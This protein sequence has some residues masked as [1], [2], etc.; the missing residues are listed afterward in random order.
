MHFNF[1]VVAVKNYG[2]K[3]LIQEK[4]K[5]RRIQLLFAYQLNFRA[6][7]LY[8]STNCFASFIFEGYSS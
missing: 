5:R 7:D 3:M 8:F 4:H 6:W 2:R 1:S